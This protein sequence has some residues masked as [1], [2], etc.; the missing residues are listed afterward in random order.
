MSGEVTA[1]KTEVLRGRLRDRGWLLEALETQ[2]WKL[3]EKKRRRVNSRSGKK[4]P[5]QG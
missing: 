2:L 5:R 4:R 3:E 1:K